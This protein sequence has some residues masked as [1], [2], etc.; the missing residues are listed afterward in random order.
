MGLDGREF[1]FRRSDITVLVAE[2]EALAAAAN[3]QQW[4]NIGPDV[5]ERQVHTGSWAWRVF[6]S[7]GPVI[8]R[9]T[10]FPAHRHRGRMEPTQLGV[11]HATGAK[12]VER[13]AAAGVGLP[14]GW[15]TVEDHTRRGLVLAIPP[16]ESH[17]VVVQFAMRAI[18]VLSPFEFDDHYLATIY[19][20]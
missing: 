1:S 13:L 16:G 5:D 6:S 20:R 3:G 8:P 11:S 9:V 15:V 14:A 7:R 18:R 4:I 12:A 2:M 19:R 10:W 17:D